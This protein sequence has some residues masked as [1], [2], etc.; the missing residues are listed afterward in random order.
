VARRVVVRPKPGLPKGTSYVA[1]SRGG[2]LQVFRGPDERQRSLVLTK[3]ISAGAPLTVLVHKVQR[4]SVQIY[5]PVRPNGATGWV[6]A[7]SVKLLTTDLALTIRLHSHRL[8]VAESGRTMRTISI[9]VGRAVTPTPTGTYF[10]TE[11]LKQ[12]D[13]AGAYGPYAFGLSAYSGVIQQFGRGGNGQVGIHGTNEP[14]LVGTDVSHGCIRLRNS[15]IVWL[16]KRLPL[17]TPVSID[18]S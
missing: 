5:L 2:T 1:V 10:I 9:G 17:G 15:D 7:S 18:R 14:Q 6:K 13:P 4:G 16:T 12:P 3:A 8:V 11:L